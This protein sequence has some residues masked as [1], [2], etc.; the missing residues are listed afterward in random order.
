MRSFHTLITSIALA[1]LAIPVGAQSTGKT[2]AT[3]AKASYSLLGTWRV[4]RGV[5]APWV[6][7]QSYH[8]DT[9]AW[10]GKTVRFDAQRVV[11]VSPL[12][13]AQAHYE[14]TRMPPDMLF[15]GGLLAPAKP[16][17]LELGFKAFPV[18]GTSF[19]GE[20]GRA[21]WRERV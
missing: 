2:R 20:I 18:G 9:R 12:N 21:S 13:C 8:P 6:K 19:T 11:G 16:A 3:S 1:A 7:D 14:P 4:Q 10:L 15:Q 5:V 17:A